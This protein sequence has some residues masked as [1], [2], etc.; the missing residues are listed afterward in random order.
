LSEPLLSVSRLSVAYLT[1]K[2]PVRAVQDASF[3]IRPGEILGL[4]GESG[5]GK[6]TV[7]KGAL[8]ILEAPGVVT[9]GSVH[10]AKTDVLAL[11]PEALRHLRWRDMSLVVQSALSSLNPVLT[12]R[13]HFEDTLRAHDAY[14]PDRAAELLELVDIDVH[15]LDSY[16]HQLSGG[17]RQRVVLALAL[18]LQPPLIVLD[19]PTTAL[20]VVVQHEILR[21]ILELQE[22]LG[23]AML[24]ITHDLPLLLDFATHIAVMHQGRIVEQGAVSVFREG[25][26]H[27][28][29]QTLLSAIP[30]LDDP[31]QDPPH[32]P[33][34]KERAPP[35]LEV[36][37]LST[38]FEI[39]KGWRSERLHAVSDVSFTLNRG[40]IVALVGES[41][42]GKSTIGRLILRLERATGGTIL[43][44]G[45]DMLTTERRGASRG[46][47]RRVQMIFQD[48]FGSL[49]NIHTVLH[50]LA[51]PLL[52]AGL[53]TPATVRDQ[54]A[55]LLEECGLSPAESFLDSHPHSLSGGQRQRVAIARALAPQPEV[56]IADEPTS[57]LDVSIR[58]DVLGLLNSLRISRG[59]SILF[60]THDLAA[61][62]ML[63]DRVVVL[64]QGKI[65]ETLDARDLPNNATHPYTQLLMQAVP[66][67]G[68]SVRDPLPKLPPP[69][70]GDLPCD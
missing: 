19:E 40:E 36:R 30:S 13:Q 11:T 39:Q 10:L 18:A 46:Y 64:Y 24:F 41:G 31:P 70:D 62:K 51:R 67:A 21:Q 33:A 47:R 66:R 2:G 61:A 50:H 20:D 44:D 63:A 25:G 14:Q 29:T 42:S 45:Q 12:V 59:I 9:S 58:K 22:K 6:S 37:N 52:R 1:P 48:P 23:F 5:S 69:D 49:N 65:M 57:M 7:A 38:W 55:T 26:T 15:H 32:A 17:M 35:R 16:P 4:V 3:T 53:A 28:Y 56:I 27:P 43:L 60:I 34:T 8:R 68:T 54:A